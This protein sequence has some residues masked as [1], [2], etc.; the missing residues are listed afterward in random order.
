M[1]CFAIMELGRPRPGTLLPKAGSPDAI[2][3]YNEKISLKGFASRRFGFL[4]VMGRK[5]K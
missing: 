1:T 5:Y 3:D 2:W 4:L